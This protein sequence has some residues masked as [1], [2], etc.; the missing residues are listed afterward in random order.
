LQLHK[1]TPVNVRLSPEAHETRRRLFWAIFV[2]DQ[3]ISVSQ[4]R[5]M[6]F[7][8]VEPEADLPRIDNEDPNDPEEINIVSDCV[9][10]IKLVKI[11]HHSLILVRKVL[12]RVVTCDETIPQGNE[13]Y[14]KLLHWKAN[15]PSRLQLQSNMS[16]S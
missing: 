16:P 3:F 11:N 10:K 13:L 9:E 5:T 4:G 1:T 6:S 7:R 12:T 15:L 14:Q 8:E 2:L